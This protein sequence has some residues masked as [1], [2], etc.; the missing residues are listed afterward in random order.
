MRYTVSF[1]VSTPETWGQDDVLDFLENAINNERRRTH[2]W[3]GDGAVYANL[4]IP[5]GATVTKQV[6]Q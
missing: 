6:D 3:G 4:H 5:G 1:E 2:A